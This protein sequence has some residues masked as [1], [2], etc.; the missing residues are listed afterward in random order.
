MK[1]L[2]FLTLAFTLFCLVSACSDT[3][4]KPGSSEETSGVAEISTTIPV[5]EKTPVPVD[6]SARSAEEMVAA[7][8]R[9]YGIEKGALI[10]RIDGAMK[11][12]EHIYFDHWGW[13]EAKYTRTTTDVGSLQEH[14]NQ[15]QYLEGERRYVYDPETNT[16]NYFDSP[17]VRQS[18]EKYQT[19]DMVKVGIEMLKN[20]GGK[21]AGTGKIGDID[22]D[23]WEIEQY[24]TTLH[25]WQGLTMKEQS[26]AGNIP[27]RR[28]CVQIETDKEVPLERLL[29]PAGAKIVKAGN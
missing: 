4:E 10:F 26:F 25:M 29:L 15:V 21:P 18:A 8:Y 11:G 20:M 9:R 6:G 14:T 5:A 22:C 24:R 3:A 7:G 19:R 23:I 16:A 1:K 2:R 17:Q 12:T 13:R 27:V 28:A